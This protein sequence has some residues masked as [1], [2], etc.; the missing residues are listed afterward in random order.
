MTTKTI[1]TTITAGYVLNTTTSPTLSI[2]STGVISKTVASGG[3]AAIYG[4]GGAGTNWTIDNSGTIK[5]TPTGVFG[6]NL[7][8]FGPTVTS[9]VIINN[10]GGL[11]AGQQYGIIT[12][13]ATTITNASGGTLSAN[14]NDIVFLQTKGTVINFGLAINTDATGLYLQGGGVVFNGPT[15]TISI[16]TA[17]SGIGIRLNAVGTVTNAGTIIGGTGGAVG[18]EATSSA[19]YLIVDPSAV[20]QGGING[21]TGKLK[22]VNSVTAAGLGIFSSSGITNF[23]TLNFGSDWTIK[24]TA[25]ATSAA[26]GFG[27]MSMTGFTNTDT[28]DLLN[29]AATSETFGSNALVVTNATSAH[30]TIHI[31]G[32]FTTNEFNLS[33][34]QGTLGTQITMLCFV[35]GTGIATPS[36]EVPVEHLAIGDMVSTQRG[37]A[38]PI[39]W[40]GTGAVLATRGRRSAATP[41]IVRKGALAH[42]VPTQDLRITKGHSLYID[43]VLI[44]VE[45]LVNHRSIEWD[46]RAQEVK[47]FHIELETH[48]VLIANG[49]PAESY[50]DDGNRWLFRNTNDG[51]VQPPQ[52]PC[53]PVVAGGKLVDEAWRRLLDRAGPRPGLPLTEDPDL[54]LLVDGQRLDAVSQHGERYVFALPHAPGQVRIASR[55]A[56]PAELGLARDPRVLG[57]ALHQIMLRQPAEM[58]LIEAADGSLA[59]GFH[60]YEPDKLF[61]W[62][63]GD[64]LLPAALFDSVQGGFELELHIACRAHYMADDAAVAIA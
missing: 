6:I 60:R 12:D 57:V 49:A 37:A 13:G 59:E 1:S 33:S 63:D 46:D 30:Q 4:A 52:Q 43:H 42:N 18:F 47:L 17:V 39:T 53:A 2:T 38:R 19:N 9:A 48:D 61:R 23:G 22:L 45:E 40:I 16:D 54:H 31:Q 20:F 62:T 41:V 35:A 8:Y 36:G 51:S 55:A 10:S 56:A 44:P 7:G 15:G 50:R 14:G 29:F 32:S 34:Y 27:N 26:T 3:H 58:R 28:I 11:I 25:T 24:A 5:G 21:G 64:A